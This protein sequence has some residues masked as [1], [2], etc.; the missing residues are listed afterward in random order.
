MYELFL[1][2]YIV[3]S[4]DLSRSI[5]MSDRSKSPMLRGTEESNRRRSHVDGPPQKKKKP[6]KAHQ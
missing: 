1:K 3:S 4:K 5:R 6:A 2:L